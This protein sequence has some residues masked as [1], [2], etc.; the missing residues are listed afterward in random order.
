MRLGHAQLARGL[1]AGVEEHVQAGERL[2]VLRRID[3]LPF[4]NADAHASVMA[5]KY[6]AER[7]RWR[8]S[9][10]AGRRAVIDDL[11]AGRPVDQEAA[12]R[13]LRYDPSHTHVATVL[14][15]DGTATP[16]PT[17]E[18]LH[19]AA[20]AVARALEAVGTLIIPAHGKSVWAW[21]V[22]PGET[23]EGHT[24][25]IRSL[26]EQ[27]GIRAALGPPAPGPHGMRRSHLGALQAQRMAGHG[28]RS[29]LCD[30]RD[31]RLAALLT[32]DLEHARWFV[33]EVLGPLASVG[34]RLHELRETQRVY[35][36]EE[37]SLRTAAELLHVARNT[38][39]YRVKRA[40]ELL[41]T[42]TTADS[43]LELRAALEIAWAASANATPGSGY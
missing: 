5:E 10:E 17:A 8:R 31:I 26:P 38:V 35:L 2:A 23:A 13:R 43:S 16:A 14:W 12:A 3:D 24:R 21:F 18:R 30:Y 42:T 6:F 39:I 41:P 19:H 15:H 25:H 20:S 7:D 34:A 29:W 37:R 36:A 32:A 40:E 1:A 33:Q 9:D 11:L 22:V 4:T 27:A 28:T